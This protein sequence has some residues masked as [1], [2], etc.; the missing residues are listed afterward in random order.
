M[1]ERPVADI[2]EESGKPEEFFDIRGRGKVF[3]K[4]ARERGIE[5]FR[6][7]TCHMHRPEGV[8]KAGMFG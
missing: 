5:S 2:M 3:T 8:L 6:K 1:A 7:D 4:D